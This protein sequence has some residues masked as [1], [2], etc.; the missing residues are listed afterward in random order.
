MA[1]PKRTASKE[2]RE[3]G[4]DYPLSGTGKPVEVAAA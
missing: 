1:T 4:R 2:N 3:I